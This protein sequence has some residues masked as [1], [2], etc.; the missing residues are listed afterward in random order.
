MTVTL[1]VWCPDPDCNAE[2]EVEAEIEPGGMDGQD[3]DGNRG[4]WVP[5]QVLPPYPPTECPKCHRHFDED[6][7][8]EM[9]MDLEEAAEKYEVDDDY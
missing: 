2:I 7:Q 4:W 8:H 9:E 6:E 1:T 5:A 3:A